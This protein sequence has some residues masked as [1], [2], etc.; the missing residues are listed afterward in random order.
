MIRNTNAQSRLLWVDAM[1]GFSMILVV[2]AHVLGGMGIG[3]YNTFLG[4]F[5]LTFRM[6]LFFFV[7]GYFSYR[8]IQWW[9]KS[10]IKD[11]LKRKIQ[12]QII[13]TI[14]F[15]SL[16][17]YCKGLTFDGNFG[18]YWFTIVLFQMYVIYLSLSLFA[19]LIKKNIV[20]ICM[21]ILSLF[22]IILIA[23]H[24]NGGALWELLSWL[25]FCKY[26]QFFTLGIIVSQYRSDFFKLLSKDWLITT[27]IILWVI[28]L[29]LWYN[30]T[31]KE[32]FS[33][34]Y[35]VVHDIIIRYV[36]LLTIISIFYRNS[37]YFSRDSKDSRILRFIG[38]RTLDIY[39]IHFFF[40]PELTPFLGWIKS[41]DLL[42]IQMLLSF[43]LTL[44][45]T[46]ASLF[47]SMAIRESKILSQWLFGVKYI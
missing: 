22:G 23:S 3:S 35:S 5:F 46:F 14:V 37:E 33:I 1:R 38:Q 31:F 13:C 20:P 6:P 17:M 7:S 18:G 27:T 11:I 29:V 8:S 9:N 39:M 47:V 41:N 32:H 34:A 25:D 21:I 40:L 45:I 12:A 42:I 2:L 28:C 43:T 4:S 24:F 15:F 10:R 36:S 19:R 44:V 16:Y 26:L 30:D